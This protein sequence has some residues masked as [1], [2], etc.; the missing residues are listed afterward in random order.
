M[1][2]APGKERTPR[3]RKRT[4]RSTSPRH[5]RRKK[6]TGWRSSSPNRTAKWSWSLRPARARTGA[7]F[8]RRPRPCSS[9]QPQT[10]SPAAPPRRSCEWHKL[11]HSLQGKKQT[12]KT[13]ICEMVVDVCLQGG[14]SYSASLRR[15]HVFHFPLLLPSCCSSMC[16]EDLE[17]LQAHKIWKKAIM[18][19]W[20]AAAN[21]RSEHRCTI[22][23]MRFL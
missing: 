10:Q 19:V 7:A 4:A 11:K 12:N 9:T 16:S 1:E 2:S 21:H 3:R 13:L 14:A 15:L 20:R 22:S 5:A 17:A 6:A 8:T 18:L 23:Q